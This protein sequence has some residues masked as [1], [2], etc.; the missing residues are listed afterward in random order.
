MRK[1]FIVASLLVG[2]A[3]AC[4][5]SQQNKQ[6]KP[7]RLEEVNIDAVE[8]GAPPKC[9]DDSGGPRECMADS[10]CCD[11]FYCGI[12]PEGSARIRTCLA[13]E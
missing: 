6:S 10:D 3:V 9:T 5:G 2:V 13:A 7:P 11:G 4:G 8:T 1:R 12:D